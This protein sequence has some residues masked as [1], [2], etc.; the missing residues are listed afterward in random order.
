MADIKDS[1]AIIKVM[2]VLAW[3]PKCKDIYGATIR[4]IPKATML[5]AVI[6]DI[7]NALLLVDTWLFKKTFAEIN[8]EEHYTKRIALPIMSKLSWLK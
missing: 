6:K 4:L 3:S 2:N 5:P 8:N 7:A 1:A